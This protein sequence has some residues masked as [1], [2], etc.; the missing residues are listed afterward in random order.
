MPTLARSEPADLV[1]LRARYEVQDQIEK[2]P[3]ETLNTNFAGAMQRLLEQESKSG[4]LDQVLAVK[5]EIERFSGG[6]N[7]SESAYRNGLSNNRK[8]RDL[9][10]MYLLSRQKIESEMR[11]SQLR[12]FKIYLQQLSAL[13]KKYTKGL[14]IN[15]A[16]LIKE[17][18]RKVTVKLETLKDPNASPLERQE[19]VLHIVAKGENEVYVNGR[20]LHC[21]NLWR[22]E[23][24][25]KEP[26]ND[27]TDG[28]SAPI[29]IGV[30]DVITLNLK[31]NAVFRGAAIGFISE[32]EKKHVVFPPDSF[33]LIETGEEVKPEDADATEFAKN[34]AEM[35]RGCQPD[36]DMAALWRE[37]GIEG[38]KFV[39]PPEKG[40]WAVI[41]A[42]IT[43]AMIV[44]APIETE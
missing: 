44:D 34:A 22:E 29:E 24:P 18:R 20:K 5:E 13:E 4:E 26:E 41:T 25:D 7:F 32:D 15:E 43:D 16:L 19:M 8:I 17:E 9:Q 23:V 40:V 33:R 35:I 1:D 12:L 38:S 39:Q 42:V 14:K 31:G 10:E 3:L 21:R 11:V 30:G 6:R 28:K 2:A 37:H 27:Y 36:G